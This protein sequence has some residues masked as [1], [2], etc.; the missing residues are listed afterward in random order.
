MSSQTKFRYDTN[1]FMSEPPKDARLVKKLFRGRENE[2]QL[3]VDILKHNLDYRGSRR[4]K[5]PWVIHGES[6]CGKSHLARRVF[7]EL[8]GSSKRARVIVSARERLEARN[9]MRLLFEEV[10]EIFDQRTGQNEPE[11]PVGRGLLELTRLLVD[12]VANFFGQP[13]EN[14]TISFEESQAKT[15]EIGTKLSIVP[16]IFSLMGRYRGQAGT[17]EGMQLILR[18]PTASDLAEYIAGMIDTM[19]RLGVL[20]HILI[21]LDD[22]DLI[23]GFAE[24]LAPGRMQRSL[25]TD[26]IFELHQQPGVDI[27][28][29]A[30]SW[31][32]HAHEDLETL[33]DLLTRPMKPEDLIEIHHSHFDAFSPKDYPKLFLIDEALELAAHDSAGLPGVF[34]KHLKIA[35]H[36]FKQDASWEPRGYEWFL[37]VFRALYNELRVPCEG[38]ATLIEKALAEGR[39]NI[40]LEQINP[41]RN[42]RL[43]GE[44]VYQSYHNEKGFYIDPMMHKLV[45]RTDTQSDPGGEP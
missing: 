7:Y 39:S 43:M 18:P 44:F 28:V 23:E 9:V 20:T 12:R 34:L 16:K 17:K 14:L 27:L 22:V 19:R 45:V 26:A 40:D 33:V 21:L 3:A 38:G 1:L 36:A 42:T 15:I 10:R 37:D 32:A 6:R 25:L 29:T 13:S 5:K 8:P 41:F 2:L 31:Y 11:E 35:F 30:R 4:D 24:D